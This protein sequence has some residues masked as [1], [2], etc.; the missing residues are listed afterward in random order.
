MPLPI[1]ILSLICC[2]MYTGC[3]P[4]NRYSDGTKLLDYKYFTIRVP[5]SWKRVDVKGIDSFVGRIEIDSKTHFGFDM[6]MYC[7]T[8]GE[9]RLT[10]YY[11]IEEGNL[12]T[13]DSS[14]K[15]NLNDPTVWKSVGEATEANI[16]KLRRNQV[17]W[18]TIDHYNAK[19][20]T[21]K[22]TGVGITGIYIDSLWK[23]GDGVDAFGL[24]AENLN[25]YQQ[26]Q[27]L[28]AIKTLKFYQHPDH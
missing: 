4:S 24:S 26:Q 22:K 23:S 13:P 25:L 15:Q 5:Q 19:I 20:V 7:D 16:E 2:F 18:A 17:T 8:L 9:G 21:P 14:V 11:N 6:G 10:S 12:Y 27:L 3:K 1:R 28:K